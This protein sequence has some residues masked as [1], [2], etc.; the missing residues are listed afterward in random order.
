MKPEIELKAN[1]SQTEWDNTVSPESEIK[2]QSVY[3]K[4]L[5]QLQKQLA[6]EQAKNHELKNKKK[7]T[8]DAIDND[9]NTLNNW[10]STS[11][12]E[13]KKIS[14]QIEFL[15][16]QIN[17]SKSQLDIIDISINNNQ[18]NLDKKDFFSRLINS[19]IHLL[20][21]KTKYE[22]LEDEYQ[23]DKKTYL[24]KKNGYE[25][26]FN[27]KSDTLIKKKTEEKDKILSLSEKI[28]EKEVLLATEDNITNLSAKNSILTDLTDIEK[29]VKS[30]LIGRCQ[31]KW[32]EQSLSPSA[33]KVKAALGLFLQNPSTSTLTSLQNTMSKNGAYIEN[34]TLKTLLMEVYELYP[35]VTF[36]VTQDEMIQA[37]EQKKERNDAVLSELQKEKQSLENEIGQSVNFISRENREFIDK[38]N[39]DALKDTY[40]MLFHAKKYQNRAPINNETQIE[41]VRDKLAIE[42]V[43]SSL[44]NKAK[45]IKLNLPDP[46]ILDKF[47]EQLS[48]NYSSKIL[49]PTIDIDQSKDAIKSILKSY[50]TGENPTPEEIDLQK[51][52]YFLSKLNSETADKIKNEIQSL[53]DV[54]SQ[55]TKSEAL[56]NDVLDYAIKQAVW[57]V[58]PDIYRDNFKN[59]QGV[60]G[61]PYLKI[62]VRDECIKKIDSINLP[63]SIDLMHVKA[64]YEKFKKTVCSEPSPSLGDFNA[65]F[66]TLKSSI[67]KCSERIKNTYKT[68]FKE[69]NQAIEKAFE[70][71]IIEDKIKFDNAPATISRINE[72]SNK[73]AFLEL[74]NTMLSERRLKIEDDFSQRIGS[75]ALGRSSSVSGDSTDEENVSSVKS[76]RSSENS[77]S[78]MQTAGNTVNYFAQIAGF[79]KKT[80]NALTESALKALNSHSASTAV[81]TSDDGKTDTESETISG[82]QS[83][84]HRYQAGKIEKS[85]ENLDDKPD[86]NTPGSIVSPLI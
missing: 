63:D 19:V 83:Y 23:E 72:L 76:N 22:K 4:K 55:V 49:G 29:S 81:K 77:T 48:T 20:W 42:N 14:E 68:Q 56:L 38:M 31:S 45:A 7:L 5:I 6:A 21:G 69:T 84:K 39:T 27:D 78:I 67:D 17:N 30:A 80:V 43:I 1:D 3:E 47:N 86:N 18:L 26:E 82:T 64:V 73:I 41:I 12:E 61:N 85:A 16:Q 51:I 40:I 25:D 34:E 62:S 70:N 75:P 44:E 35:E 71:T 2:I 60:P 36:A 37:V 59:D 50:E 54:T 11:K 9:I 28:K 46:N 52:V 24:R 53:S 15:K 32:L 13:I 8:I 58:D 74:E 57:I 65:A 33:A 79:R 10:L 66:V